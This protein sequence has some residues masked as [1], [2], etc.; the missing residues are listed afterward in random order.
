LPGRVIHGSR[1]PR[2]RGGSAGTTTGTGTVDTGEPAGHD[3]TTGTPKPP[4]TG[5]RGKLPVSGVTTKPVVGGPAR[6]PTPRP[7][8]S[9]RIKRPDGK[10][11]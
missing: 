4:T 3:G 5:G 7:F 8:P 2:T 10:I 1:P 11:R 6:T 9:K